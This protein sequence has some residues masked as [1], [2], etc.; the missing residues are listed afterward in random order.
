[1]DKRTQIKAVQTRLAAMGKYDV[2]VFE[3]ENNQYIKSTETFFDIMT[4]GSHAIIQADEAIYAWCI[5]TFK[6]TDAKRIMDG[7]NLFALES[8]LRSYSK[9]LCG[10][11][12]RYLYLDDSKII[13]KPRGFSYK[14]FER[15][16]MEELWRNKGF[17]NALNYK[18]DV[19]AFGAF[20]GD[21]LVALAGSDDR[22]GDMWQIGIDTLPAFRGKGLGVYLVKT[23]ADEI[24][25]RNA[26]PY[27]TT[28]TQTLHP[29]PLP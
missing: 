29:P 1:M 7:E 23:L 15:E 11:Q 13:N 21:E 25:Q 14:L 18:D 19:L 6:E 5:K 4:F 9:K 8:K 12:V 17:N 10:E 16:G 26:I 2:S 28:W 24:A 20:C 22:M 27:Y 3:Q